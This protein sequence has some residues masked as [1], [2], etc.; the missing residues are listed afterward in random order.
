MLNNLTRTNYLLLS[1]RAIGVAGKSERI[2]PFG[3]GG[4]QP[5]S[6]TKIVLLI[7]LWRRIDYERKDIKIP[8]GSPE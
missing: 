6:A 2:S 3:V 8:G 1:G 7:S 5:F 4:Y